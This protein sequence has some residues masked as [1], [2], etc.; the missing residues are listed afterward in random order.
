MYIDLP[1]SSSHQ[2]MRFEDDGHLKLY[3]WS[4]GW[5]FLKD[6]LDVFLDDCAYPTVCGQYGICL[7]GQCSCP[8][9]ANGDSSFFN[10]VNPLQI[11]L[12]CRVLTLISSSQLSWRKK[13]VIG[14]LLWILF[15]FC[16]DCS[17]DHEIQ[18]M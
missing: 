5:K 6:V 7:N 14:L 15:L 12:G 4:G 9:A 16:S 3:G 13:L 11:N 18:A 17:N 1:S 8:Q 2:Y 10:S